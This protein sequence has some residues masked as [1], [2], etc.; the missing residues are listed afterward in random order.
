MNRYLPRTGAWRLRRTALVVGS[1]AGAAAAA[2]ELQGAFEVIV[3]ESADDAHPPALPPGAS[4][5]AGLRGAGGADALRLDQA[6]R[7]LGIDLD[8]EFVQLAQEL[9]AATRHQRRWSPDTWRLFE[10]CRQMSLDPQVTPKMPDA[11]CLLEEAV[12][13]G[14]RRV[15]AA[16]VLRVTIDGGRA[17]GVVALQGARPSLLPASLVILAAGGLL[18]PSILRRSGI[19]CGPARFAEP[20]LQLSA[21]R[22]GRDREIP[23]PFMVLREGFGLGPCLEPRSLCLR[24]LLADTP[25]APDQ[26]PPAQDRA[27]RQVAVELGTEI[28]RRFGVPREDLRLE[29]LAA[30]QPGGALPLTA[31]EAHSL[32]P[33]ALPENLYVADATLLPSALGAPHLLTILALARRVARAAG[34]RARELRV[35]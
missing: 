25:R 33:A 24:I 15:R 23:T 18:T 13:R 28:F 35:S 34:E 9:P 29:E 7:E 2:L 4:P 32:H 22:P 19:E 30:G 17:T 26:N 5:R 31:R 3:L 20:V 10:L 11:R 21:L 16:R 14:A 27:R 1:D 6:L 8:R 12:S